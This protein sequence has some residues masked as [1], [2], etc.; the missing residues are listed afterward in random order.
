[1]NSFKSG[2][3]KIDK[4]LSQAPGAIKNKTISAVEN[5]KTNQ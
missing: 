2:L 3:S 1:M 4:A 5:Y